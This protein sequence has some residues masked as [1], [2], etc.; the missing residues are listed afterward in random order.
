MNIVT[1]ELL[2]D[3]DFGNNLIS[4]KEVYNYKKTS[5]KNKEIKSKSKSIFLETNNDIK[6]KVNKKKIKND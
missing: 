2:I 5:I 1:I 6:K 4:L 3:K